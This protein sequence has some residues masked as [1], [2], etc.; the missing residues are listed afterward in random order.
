[1]NFH[2]GTQCVNLPWDAKANPQNDR[3]GDDALVFALAN[4]YTGHNAPMHSHTEG[5]FVNGVT[6]GY[7]W[8]QVL[9]G[10]QDWSINTTASTHVTTELSDVKWPDASELPTFWKDNRDSMVGWLDSGITGFHLQVTDGAGQP[11]A[12]T[13]DIATAKR[14]LQYPD[15]FVH[16]PA[17]GGSQTV[18]VKADSYRTQVLTLTPAPFEG[19]YT[20]VVMRK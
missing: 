13:V 14:S 20:S 17:I 15:G 9:G 2:G 6:Y 1:M 16:R 19:Q 4:D 12:A 18:T 10:M 3:F 7:E 5:S 11:V 8:Y